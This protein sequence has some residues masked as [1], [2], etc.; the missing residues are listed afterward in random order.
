MFTVAMLGT[1]W[2]W[3]VA[4][5][6]I[7][8]FMSVL[9]DSDEKHYFTSISFVISLLLLQFVAKIDILSWLVNHGPA[10]LTYLCSHLTLG[11]LWSIFKWY[12]FVQA[13]LKEYRQ[14]KTR[15]L[16]EFN[17]DSAQTGI[18]PPD[19][20]TKWEAEIT[21]K[22]FWNST[23]P[24]L[25][26]PPNIKDH[27]NKVATWIFYWPISMTCSLLGD[28]TSWLANKIVSF[29]KRVYNFISDLVFSEL[30]KD[31][32]KEKEN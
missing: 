12:C 13:S 16:M 17:P 8:I 26:Y 31:L 6:T 10:L 11:T 22:P 2:F 19:L 25:E 27:K 28:F 9:L 20:K 21:A 18:M 1:L 29:I 3:I 5:E 4:I 7:I 23:P 24:R 15:F 30:K 32:E 14:R